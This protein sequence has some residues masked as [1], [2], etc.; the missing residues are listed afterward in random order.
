MCLKRAGC[1]ERLYSKLRVC[2][3]E[4]LQMKLVFATVAVA[5]LGWC[6]AC[7]SAT[8][9]LL[10]TN[11]PATAGSSAT[12]AAVATADPTLTTANLLEFSGST[13]TNTDPFHLSAPGKIEVSWQNLGTGQLSVW[14]DNNDEFATDPNY[15]HILVKNIDN[16]KAS[17]QA[18]I[19]LITGNYVV[20]VEIA[21]GPWKITVKLL[22]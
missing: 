4:M 2:I 3:R 9:T 17:G 10:P 6:T 16:T 21:D 12:T 14:I 5:V 15:D 22:P 18:D 13:F 20:D 8:P 19:S 11:V 7:G 1:D